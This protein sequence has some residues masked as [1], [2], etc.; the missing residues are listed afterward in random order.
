MTHSFPTRRSSDLRQPRAF[1][2]DRWKQK[3]AAEAASTRASVV[4]LWRRWGNPSP[5]NPPLEGEGF[6]RSPDLRVDH[7]KH[8]RERGAE[9]EQ[10]HVADPEPPILQDRHDPALPVGRTTERRVRKEGGST[11]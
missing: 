3:L 10:H 1:R 2:S 4:D 8:C 9:A 11:V 6:Q 7:G 5:P